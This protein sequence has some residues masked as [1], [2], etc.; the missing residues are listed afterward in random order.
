MITKFR[1]YLWWVDRWRRSTA[2]ID[3]TLEEQGAYRN[4]LDEAAQRGGA[5]P[6]DEEALAK[7][8]GDPRAW[9]RVREK[10]LRKFY[11]C[12]EGLRNETLDGV[13]E[14]SRRQS[15]KQHRYR[16]RYSNDDGN[17]LDTNQGTKDGN[18]HINDHRP[19]IDPDPD[20]STKT[21][22]VPRSG[23]RTR[24]DRFWAAYPRKI[25]KDA[26]WREWQRLSP[27]EARTAE[28]ILAI[29]RQ[30]QT[31]QWQRDNGQYI[32]H[33]RTW[34]HQG[35]WQDE[36]D[37]VGLS[38]DGRAVPGADETAAYLRDMRGVRRG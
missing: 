5:I 14:K 17:D 33:P 11:R 23:Q 1:G 26:A 9:R 7:A 28:M 34:L 19:L 24:F 12:E 37:V 38:V 6:N 10:V 3:M 22:G 16:N 29:T 15:D 8:C 27:S 31:P 13:L 35:R 21:T 36:P 20:L 30:C 4:L 2:H 25:A 18:D 32:P